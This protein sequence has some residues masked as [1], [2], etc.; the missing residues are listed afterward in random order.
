MKFRDDIEVMVAVLATLGAYLCC[1]DDGTYLC[2]PRTFWRKEVV[3]EISTEIA[4]KL[5]ERGIQW[6]K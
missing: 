4:W 1:D 3:I 6:L 2:V 5:N